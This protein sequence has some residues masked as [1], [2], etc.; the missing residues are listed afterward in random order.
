[1][2]S[3]W[4]L[5]A[6]FPGD[7]MRILLPVVFVLA[8]GVQNPPGTPARDPVSKPTAAT[9]SISGRVTDAETGRPLG[10]ALVEIVSGLPFAQ[11]FAGGLGAVTGADGSYVITGVPPGEYV[12]VAR[13]G[14]FRATHTFA[15]FGVPPGTR[16]ITSAKRIALAAGETRAGIE[17]QLPR[18][19]AIE[20]RV[21][22]EFGEPLSGVDVHPERLDPAGPAGQG[23]RTDDRGNFR[24]FRLPPG[25]YRI[26]ATP[27]G[28]FS[29][30][31]RSSERHRARYVTT[32]QPLVGDP[33]AAGV[34]ITSADVH[35]VLIQ[36]QRSGAFT[37]SG[38]LLRESG[39]PVGDAH[40]EIRREER[41]RF[42][43]VAAEMRAGTFV[44][45]GVTPGRYRIVA[46]TRGAAGEPREFGVTDI[47]VD[48]ADVA[49][50]VVH[51][52]AG[53]R[54]KG[55]LLLE[56]GRLTTEAIRRMR[57]G[58]GSLPRFVPVAPVPRQ[59]QIADDL[60]FELQGLH[61]P[62]MPV[63]MGMP[64]GWVMKSV[65]YRGADVTG[66]PIEFVSSTDATALGIVLTNRTARLIVRLVD[67]DGQPAAGTVAA[68][69][70]PDPE[71]RKLSGFAAVGRQQ[72]DG[73]MQFQAVPA[74]EY[75]LAAIPAEDAL[76]RAVSEAVAAAARRITLVDGESRTVDVTVTP[77]GGVGR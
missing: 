55:H 56:G 1:M 10:D 41:G 66:R 58:F 61:E 14:E 65:W 5:R 38:A 64:D 31:P 13:P 30:A 76:A 43:G 34:D 23:V 44:A 3:L 53:A 54:V 16:S 32:C 18:A 35:G 9:T 21:V 37:V 25:S 63:V 39:D 74:G 73:S 51:V 46:M 28:S 29:P 2:V 11:P 4:A 17:I 50:V 15:A 57:I 20:G 48:S 69:L 75:L 19:F 45:P 12:V 47:Q 77:G 40:L 72:S 33:A 52:S 26:C 27:P 7:P 71:R 24:V 60:T 36:M 59:V 62:W 49:G 42:I 8:A 68:L 70:W 6:C 22:D 67:P